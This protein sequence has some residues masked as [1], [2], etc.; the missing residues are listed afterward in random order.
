MKATARIIFRKEPTRKTKDNLCPVKLCITYKG[1]RRYYSIADK[2]K[3]KECLFLSEA[4]IERISGTGKN[5]PRGELRGIADEYTRIV[6]DAYKI[7]DDLGQFSFN[8]F[9]EGY[10]GVTGDW[11]NVFSA[12]WQHIQDLRR[13]ERFGYASSF[14]STLR[15][16][17][18]FHTN[19]TFEFNV[20]K[21]K[22]STRKEKY[23]S[24]KALRFIDITPRW[25]K[26][27]ESWLKKKEK[28]RSTIGIYTR[29]IRVLFNLA[30]KEHKV[31]AEYPFSSYK[32]KTAKGRKIA[33][34]A[35]Q[36]GQIAAYKT[37][38][39]KEQFYRD[40]FM[41]SFFGY[42]MNLSDIARLRHSN[43][44]GNEIEF[45]REK[46]KDE[47]ASEDK[48]HVP[49]TQTMRSIIKRHGNR[50]VGHDA[51]IFPVLNPEWDEEK[52]YAAIRQLT[53]QVNDTL[54]TIAKEVGI[55]ERVSSY[56]ARHSFATIL[57]NS[58]TSTE[59][60]SEALGHSSVKVTKLYLKGFEKSTRKEHSDKLEST[61]NNAAI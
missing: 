53:K 2:T 19:Q 49:L 1:E 41:F 27:F 48:I 46:T 24:G 17:K 16:V 39:P 55:K 42:G 56:V 37:E 13:D 61:I 45:V 35:Y 25:L 36:I 26:E 43:I 34:S 6:A 51:Y 44:A 22:I 18:E 15:A 32:T 4:D 8:R 58:G 38:N 21:D 33:L 7:I 59:F 11:D 14:E 23:I 10:N 3:K 28:S 20:R 57:K 29:N 12:M 60:I 5:S 47:E 31:N 54:K 52:K 50:A 30:I 9:E 40:M